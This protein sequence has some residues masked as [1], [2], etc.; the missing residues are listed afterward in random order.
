MSNQL[1]LLQR[2]KTLLLPEKGLTLEPETPK[3][4]FV[5]PETIRTFAWLFA[6]DGA[7][8]RLLQC[9]DAGALH[10][11]DTGS[12]LSLVEVDS[13]TA[14]DAYDAGDTFLY[15]AAK[16]KVWI[17]IET[18]GATIKFYDQNGA[19]MDE[20]SLPVGVA[21]FDVSTRGGAIQNRTAGQ[22]CVYQFIWFS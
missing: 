16:S 22:N 14:N 11:A 1:G 18:Y 17:V 6:N 19:F 7:N 3:D 10:V 2:V 13:G 9:T 21:E 8:L 5:S 15:A 20:F 4:L 12:G